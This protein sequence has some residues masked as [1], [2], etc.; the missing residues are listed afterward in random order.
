LIPALGIYPEKRIRDPIHGFISLTDKEVNLIDTFVFQRLRGIKQLAHTFLVYPGATHTRFEHSLGVLESASRIADM[1]ESIR[2]DT[3]K[4]RVIRYAALLHDLGQGPFSHVFEDIIRRISNN[5]NFS[6]EWITLDLMRSNDEISEVLGDKQDSVID[7]FESKDHKIERA[8]IDGP[9]DAD[10]MDYLP[11]DSYFT[12]VAYGVFDALRVLYTLREIRIGSESYLGVDRKGLEAIQ[13]LQL[14]RYYMHETVYNHKTRRI[15]DAMIIRSIELAVEEGAIERSLFEYSPNDKDFLNS[16][17]E[18]NDAKLIN[19]VLNRSSK[20]ARDI[21]EALQKRQ[22]FKCV[23]MKDLSKIQPVP[24]RRKLSRMGKDETRNLENEIAKELNKDPS[25]VIIDRQSIRNPIY[26]EPVGIV[27]EEE[28]YIQEDDKVPQILSDISPLHSHETY[29]IEKI[30]VF[31]KVENKEERK[32]AE[33]ISYK[34]I[35]SI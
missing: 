19:M 3:D 18:L 30:L 17:V 31:V 32:K 34:V 6:H 11:R 15:A 22:L 24:L 33:D 26:R 23:Y 7:L 12:G 13:G 14:A 1:I 29:R 10:K 4:V 2:N 25:L 35:E 16:Y 9:L 20:K 8:I 28:I 5:N 27:P 21:M